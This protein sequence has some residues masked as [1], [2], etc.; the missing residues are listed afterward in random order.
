V[1]YQPMWVNGQT[2][3]AQER[4]CEGRYHAIAPHVPEGATVLDFG[5]FTGYF[6]HRLADERNAKCVAVA[7]EVL[8]YPGV[9][10]V[11]D[12]LTPDGIRQLG[13]FDVVLALSVLHHLN[14]WRDYY[15]ALADAAGVLIVEVPNRDEPFDHCLPEKVRDIHDSVKGDILCLTAGYRTDL[16]RPTVRVTGRLR[17][18]GG[19]A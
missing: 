15:E 7:P 13:K 2:I 16:L 10:I 17:M 19:N 11:K 5:A 8:P 12:K 1:I 9:T 4:D 6:S 18:P 14:P 3:G